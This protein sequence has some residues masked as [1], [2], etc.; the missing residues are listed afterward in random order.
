MA[1][2]HEHIQALI[3]DVDRCI[4]SGDDEAITLRKLAQRLGYSESYVSRKFSALSGMQLW[5]F[6][7]LILFSNRTEPF[8]NRRQVTRRS[9]TAFSFIASR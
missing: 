1:Q 3:D 8:N 7:R 5:E 9:L 2:W 4:L 6:L